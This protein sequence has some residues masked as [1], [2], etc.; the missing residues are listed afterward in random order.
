MKVDLILPCLNEAAALPWVLGRLPS[1]VR[2]IVVDNG[3]TDD[4]PAIATTHGATV[5][6]C[7]IKGYGAACHAGLEAS[8]APIVA[9][10][11]ADASLD[12]RQLVRVIAPIEAGSS[13][14]MLGRRKPVSRDA[15]PWHLRLAN[16]ELARRIRRRTG[17]TLRDL[18]PMRAARR[19][20][21]LGLG[22]TDRRS[23]YPL[24]TVVRAS[25]A[26]WRIA[27]VDVDYLPRSGR[28]KVTGTPLGAARAVRDMSKVLAT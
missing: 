11:D 13:D 14:L 18:G 16:A 3:S 20:A 6:H 9:F 19:E 25:D 1:G 12:P 15:W 2:A 8:T 26:G 4:S 5:V 17:L 22:I 23:G 24:E 27:E 7:A 21:L 28:S 10:L